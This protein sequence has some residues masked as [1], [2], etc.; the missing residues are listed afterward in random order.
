MPRMASA[1]SQ[2]M[3]LAS[4]SSRMP[5]PACW[6]R[7]WQR[8]QE[9]RAAV[10]FAT[11]KS[12]SHADLDALRAGEPGEELLALHDA[13]E[14]FATHDPFKAKLVELHFF[15]GLTLAQTAD[16][17]NIPFHRRPRLALRPRLAVRRHG[18]RRFR[19]II[20]LV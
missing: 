14:Q 9:M 7:I 13:L 1:D 15:A 16:C 19:K 20:P 4:S 10:Q 8:G 6:P 5:L 2:R 17:L 3:A 12:Q 11:F 18:R